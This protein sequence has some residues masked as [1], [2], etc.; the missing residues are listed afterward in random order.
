MQRLRNAFGRGGNK[1]SSL[2]T[3]GSSMCALS[4]NHS[5]VGSACLALSVQ[6]SARHPSLCTHAEAGAM[7]H[8]LSSAPSPPAAS[9]A[10]AAAAAPPP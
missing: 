8:G 7:A 1:E 10:V 3:A 2:D 9:A 6:F 5:A 4:G